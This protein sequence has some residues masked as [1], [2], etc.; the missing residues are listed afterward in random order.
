ELVGHQGA[1]AST[2]DYS[3]TSTADI[4]GPWT[5]AVRGTVATSGL[6]ATTQALFVLAIGVVV[7][8]LVAA[9]ARVLMRAR[10]R[11]LG[12]VEEKTGEL[13]HQALHDALTDL[14]NRVLALDR[15]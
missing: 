11:A 10:E 13:R 3:D 14:P 2:G 8:L 12:L 15:A 1:G 9:L 4:E 7:T 5:V 6:S